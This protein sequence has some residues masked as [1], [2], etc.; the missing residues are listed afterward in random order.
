MQSVEKKYYFLIDLYYSFYY[1]CI[2]RHAEA[3]KGM[4]CGEHYI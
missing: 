3:R 2:V 4:R 1:I